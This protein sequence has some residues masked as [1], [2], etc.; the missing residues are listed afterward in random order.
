MLPYMLK[1]GVATLAGVGWGRG[2]VLALCAG[3]IFMLLVPAVAAQVA[4]TSERLKAAFIFRFPQFVEWPSAALAGRPSVDLCVIEAE[5]VETALDELAAGAKPAGLGA[6]GWG[7][8]VAS[9]C[10]LSPR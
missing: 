10:C 4:T 1:Q 7:A 3:P 2:F 9:A 8:M 6:R 5:A